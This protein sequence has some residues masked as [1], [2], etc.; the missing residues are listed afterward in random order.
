MS[1]LS[2]FLNEHGITAEQV[3]AQSV[4]IEHVHLADR[5]LYARRIAARRAKK[6]YAELSVEKP[7]ALGRGVAAKALKAA[8][9]GTP[10]P[11]IVRK[12]ILRAV[13]G[14]L[15]SKKVEA[16]D[17]RKLFADTPSRKGEKKK[18]K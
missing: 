9:E 16:V 1:M 15:A 14:V 8:L 12:K 17:W 5:E 4:A 2:D 6:P 7:K 3:L 13:N 18:T 10:Q 11:R